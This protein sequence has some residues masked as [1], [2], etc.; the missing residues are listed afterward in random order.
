MVEVCNGLGKS[1][2]PFDSWLWLWE[3]RCLDNWLAL[4]ILAKLIDVC[5]W[6]VLHV[7]VMLYLVYCFTI[8]GPDQQTQFFFLSWTSHFLDKFY[9]LSRMCFTYKKLS[10]VI[11]FV[12]WVIFL[13]LINYWGHA[14]STFKIIFGLWSS[15]LL[16]NPSE[17]ACLIYWVI[18][19]AKDIL[20]MSKCNVSLTGILV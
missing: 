9:N 3:V 19:L 13:I 18:Y 15:P 5:D 20:I 17:W 4:H 2:F 11:L 10:N 8:N 7:Y 1:L 16:H 14:Q 12:K 6:K